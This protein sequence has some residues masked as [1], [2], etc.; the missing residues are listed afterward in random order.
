MPTPGI[1]TIAERD[2][3]VWQLAVFQWQLFAE[4]VLGQRLETARCLAV[5]KQQGVI[6]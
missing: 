6:R 5:L 1:P 4:S 2:V 3:V